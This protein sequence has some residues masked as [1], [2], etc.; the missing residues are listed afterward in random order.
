MIPATKNVLVIIMILLPL[1]ITGIVKYGP[2]V[3]PKPRISS[4]SILPPHLY[5]PGQYNYMIEDVPERLRRTLSTLNG[6]QV[7]RT[8][9]PSEIGGADELVMTTV[10]F[11]EGILELTL[12]VVDPVNRQVLFNEA[13]ESPLDQYPQM[14]DSAGTALKHVIQR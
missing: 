11:D 6:V 8:P 9:L 14:V 12:E 5:A 1:M 4:I 3:L 10:T 2:S 13:F 7:R